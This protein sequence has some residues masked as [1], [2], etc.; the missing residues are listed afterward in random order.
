MPN[1]PGSGARGGVI[2]HFEHAWV[3]LLLALAALPLLFSGAKPAIYPSLDVMPPDGLATALGFALRLVGVLAIAALVF[4]LSGPTRGEQRIVRT[5]EGAQMVIVLDRSR[6]MNE[7]FAGRAPTGRDQESK[8]RAASRLL[9]D[10]V[11]KRPNN[12][13]GMA[14]FTTSPIYVLP[15]TAKE[16]AT[17]AAIKAAGSDGLG[18]TNIATPLLMAAGFFEGRA[19]QGARVILLVSDGA[20]V[21]DAQIGDVLRDAF[22]EQNVR[23]YWIYIPEEGSPGLFAQVPYDELPVGGV[24]EQ[25]LHRYFQSLGVPYTAYEAQNPAALQRAVADMDQLERWPLR[26]AELLPSKDVS[27]YAYALSL[28]MIAVLIAAK[29]FEVKIWR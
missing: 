11:R 13:Y 9:L 6:S 5:T 20:A 28:L 3:L 8:A 19:Y 7:T 10:S 29:L 22:Q 24:P 15:L 25:R 23:L 14:E 26:T 16:R 17:H 27:R 2:F 4:A 1:L 12:V 21:I 18:L